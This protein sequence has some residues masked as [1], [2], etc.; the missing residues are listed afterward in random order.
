M[1]PDM[2]PPAGVSNSCL[3]PVG[4]KMLR[5][6]GG[7]PRLRQLLFSPPLDV[8]GL[9]QRLAQSQIGTGLMPRKAFVAQLVRLDKRLQRRAAEDLTALASDPD[10][11][12]GSR[13]PTHVDVPRLHAA[14]VQRFGMK[15]KDGSR[16]RINTTRAAHRAGPLVAL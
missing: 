7:W 11:R 4:N 15:S 5:S 12:K 2:L 6:D 16:A 14:F 3:R 13:P 9:L 10:G 8:T 1:P